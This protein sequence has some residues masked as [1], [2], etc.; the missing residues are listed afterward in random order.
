MN[1]RRRRAEALVAEVM[2]RIDPFID[3]E[4]EK[5]DVYRALMGMFVDKGVEVVTDYT[6]QEAGLPPRSED[7][8]TA[9]ELRALETKRLEVLTRPLAMPIF[10]LA[11][12]NKL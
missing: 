1:L 11:P 8:W 12:L 4:A 10:P 7:G 9:D 6:R 2:N 3:R 5:R